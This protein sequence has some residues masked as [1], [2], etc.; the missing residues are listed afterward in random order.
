MALC[1]SCALPL[2]Q[3]YEQDGVCPHHHCV[4]G[5]NWAATNRVICNGLHRGEWAPRLPARER[6]EISEWAQS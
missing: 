3:R 1:A 6:E 4:Y 5:D 2:E